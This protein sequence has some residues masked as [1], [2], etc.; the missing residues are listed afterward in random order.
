MSLS[1]QQDIFLAGFKGIGRHVTTSCPSLCLSPEGLLY[2]AGW[3]QVDSENNVSFLAEA[4]SAYSFVSRALLRGVSTEK[5]E[6]LFTPSNTLHLGARE[7]LNYSLSLPVK[8]P[9]RKEPKNT[10]MLTLTWQDTEVEF[11]TS[12][13]KLP[14]PKIVDMNIVWVSAQNI[15]VPIP[16]AMVRL[17]ISWMSETGFSG[18][19]NPHTLVA[20]DIFLACRVAEQPFFNALEALGSKHYNAKHI[21]K[22]E[23]SNMHNSHCHWPKRLIE[24]VLM[25]DFQKA[26]MFDKASGDPYALMALAASVASQHP[27]ALVPVHSNVQPIVQPILQPIVHPIVQPIKYP[28]EPLIRP[29][30]ILLPNEQSKSNETICGTCGRCEKPLRK[31]QESFAC[32]HA[33]LGCASVLCIDCVGTCKVHPDIGNVPCCRIHVDA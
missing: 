23:K 20:C 25:S 27:Y 2:C 4:S 9:K 17:D 6:K 15:I 18:R 28:I 29:E 11:V 31:E 13:S 19:S 16:L 32:A 7:H 14:V 10:T 8:K 24:D 5:V 33:I 26:Q 30:T 12:A 21:E 22:L 3:V 1:P